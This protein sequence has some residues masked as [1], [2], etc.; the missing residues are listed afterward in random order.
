MESDVSGMDPIGKKR[1]GKNAKR[2][3]KFCKMKMKKL[4]VSPRWKG[5]K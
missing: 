5:K 1:F 2:K 3:R 4:L